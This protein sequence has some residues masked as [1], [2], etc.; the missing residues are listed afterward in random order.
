MHLSINGRE[1]E[2]QPNTTVLAALW[3]NGIPAPALCAMG[4]CMACRVTIDGA[5]HQL[6]CQTECKEGMRVE[7]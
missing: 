5:R 3:N 4:I 6:A 7:L 1:I 2:T